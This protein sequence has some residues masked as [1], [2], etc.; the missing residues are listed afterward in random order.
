[1]R[2]IL[3]RKEG[4]RSRLPPETVVTVLHITS[5][6]GSGG[7]SRQHRF[8]IDECIDEGLWDLEAVSKDI[9]MCVLDLVM[10]G[11]AGYI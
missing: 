9:A 8:G 2:L 4:F 6:G 7:Y 5:N 3:T 11:R 10:S 1:M